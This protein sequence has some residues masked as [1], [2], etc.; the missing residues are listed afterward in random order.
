MLYPC[1]VNLL[2]NDRET[3]DD[4]RFVAVK[5]KENIK[6]LGLVKKPIQKLTDLEAYSKIG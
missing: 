6:L 1:N 2:S 5:W 3:V 4:D